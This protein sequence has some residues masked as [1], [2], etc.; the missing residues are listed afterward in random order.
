MPPANPLFSL[1]LLPLPTVG[2]PITRPLQPL[3][4]AAAPPAATP[5]EA[6]SRRPGE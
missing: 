3:P 4:R 5:G 2:R 1:T 6:A